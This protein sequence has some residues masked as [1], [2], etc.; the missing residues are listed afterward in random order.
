MRRASRFAQKAH[1]GPPYISS[2]S[3]RR[4]ELPHLR[5]LNGAQNWGWGQA[6]AAYGPD[7]SNF[8]RLYAAGGNETSQVSRVGIEILSH[9]DTF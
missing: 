1:G 2:L 9:V 8:C 3:L 7:L 4:N 6:A 5:P